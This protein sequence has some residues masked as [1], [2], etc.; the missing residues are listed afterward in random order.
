MN[1]I[2]Y[3]KILNAIS[4]KGRQLE[5]SALASIVGL[6][7]ATLASALERLKDEG[8][9][10]YEKTEIKKYEITERGQKY[11]VDGLP[12]VKLSVIATQDPNLDLSKVKKI[13]GEESSVAIS[14]GI[15]KGYIQLRKEGTITRIK[16]LKTATQ[17]VQEL[18]HENPQEAIQR[19]II[20]ERT[21][22]VLN[23]KELPKGLHKEEQISKLTHE[24]IITGRWKEMKLKAY[25]V[26]SLPN[27]SRGGRKNFFEEF[28][29]WVREILE[30]MGFQEFNG[31]YLE[32]E[33]WNFDALFQA[34]NHPARE[35]HDIFAVNAS[36]ELEDQKLV[37][38]VAREHEAGWGYYW[39]QKKAAS[40]ILRS[41]NTAVS[42]RFLSA[43]NQGPL[44]MYSVDRVFRRDALD[45]RHHVEFYQS[46]G[47]V[48]DKGLNL[49]YLLGFLT[50]FAKQ[51][52]F[53]EVKFYPSYFP[54][55]EPSIEGYIK[56]PTLGWM[57]TLPGGIFRPEVTRPLGV[58]HPVLAWG[59][60]ISRLAMAKFGIDDIRLL[61]DP[62]L[63][64][65]MREGI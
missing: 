54:F 31:P 60:G 22:K 16:S 61:Y 40:L 30:D 2:D 45:Q 1:E 53:N 36:T 7:E 34:Q 9:I 43:H 15:K 59:I 13:F 63:G 17:T 4:K 35:L 5:L 20:K 39:D 14:W 57:E 28:L 58:K 64:V 46:E 3:N 21:E 29:N 37:R 19:G 6:T 65:L 8:I 12:E 10:S 44:K 27:A 42:A 32:A 11:E 48:V 26:T 23:F 56:H 50:Q 49:K 62:D 52:G 33:F 24:D 38:K 55:T 41:Q 18:I 51:L 47:I 25:D